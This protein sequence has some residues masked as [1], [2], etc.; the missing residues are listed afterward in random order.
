MKFISNV[1][2][3]FPNIFRKIV[4]KRLVKKIANRIQNNFLDDFLELLLK[5]VRLVSCVDKDFR[6]N[7]EGF[8]AR[9]AFKSEDGKIAAS[10]IFKNNKMQVLTDEIKD[11]NITVIFK[12]GQALWKF[13]FSGDPDIFEFILQNKLRYTGNLNYILKFGYMATHLRLKFGL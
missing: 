5:M 11:T 7:I 10:A 6:R 1:M 13:L 4:L 3:F 9:Y 12:D 8:N 2:N